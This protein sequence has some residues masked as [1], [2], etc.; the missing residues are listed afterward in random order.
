MDSWEMSNIENRP[1]N[2]ISISFGPHNKASLGFSE[3]SSILH[4][5][6]KKS[7]SSPQLKK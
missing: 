5:S 7:M 1:S 6:K 2:D 4:S 3:Q